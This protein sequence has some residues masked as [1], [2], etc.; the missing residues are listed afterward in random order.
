MAFDSFVAALRRLLSEHRDVQHRAAHRVVDGVLP[1]RV[2]E[3]H[4]TVATNRNRDVEDKLVAIAPPSEVR[5]LDGEE[6]LNPREPAD[7][8]LDARKAL[9]A[10]L[11]SRN[12]D[13]VDV[14]VV[15]GWERVGSRG[16]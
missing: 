14:L 2:G 16:S 13:D 1:P 3:D 15:E 6:L 5:L 4:I 11:V 7:Q 12:A 10:K 8:T 9:E